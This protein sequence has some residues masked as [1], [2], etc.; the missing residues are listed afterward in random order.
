MLEAAREGWRRNLPSRYE[1]GGYRHFDARVATALRPGLEILDVGPG[2]RPSVAPP[3]RP[4]NTRYVALD[5]SREELLRAAPES[6]DEIVVTDAAQ[7]SPDLIARFDLV[8]SYFALE[9]VK[10][11]EPALRNMHAYLRQGGRLLALLSGTFSVASIIGRVVPQRLATH[12]VHRLYGRDP[13][14]VFPA[15]YDRCWYS[16]LD[17]LLAREWARWE[18]VPM[19]TGARYVGFSRVLSAAYLGYEEW[20]LRSGRRNLAPYYLID[21]MARQHGDDSRM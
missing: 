21:A 13:E 17:Q 1:P 11:L 2:R 18:V 10:P 5:I 19:Y 4:P 12:L 15:Y 6:Y 3:D 7:P 9:H 16:A 8:L 14:S 20:A